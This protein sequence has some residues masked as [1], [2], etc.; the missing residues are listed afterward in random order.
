MPFGIG[1]APEN[2]TVNGF[3]C[4]GC[5]SL[6]LSLYTHDYK[7]CAC[8]NMADGGASY[9]RRGFEDFE[10]YKKTVEIYDW[11]GILV[12]AELG[13]SDVLTEGCGLTNPL[14]QQLIKEERLIFATNAEEPEDGEKELG[15]TVMGDIPDDPT[16]EE[17]AAALAEKEATDRA[18][19][20]EL[21]SKIGSLSLDG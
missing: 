5:N 9:V 7:V 10:A 12:A 19:A 15:L 20:A 18:R 14:I 16:E 17:L 4:M 1:E 11:S 6:I 8:G 2:R 13:F 21:F 3:F